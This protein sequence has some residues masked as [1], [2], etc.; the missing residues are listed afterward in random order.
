MVPAVSLKSLQMIVLFLRNARS[1]V[2]QEDMRMSL[3]DTLMAVFNKY[4]IFVTLYMEKSVYALV[5]LP[6][7]HPCGL[8]TWLMDEFTVATRKTA[9]VASG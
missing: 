5:G 9:S 7:C 1:R 4:A 2:L 8:T 3:Q 6:E